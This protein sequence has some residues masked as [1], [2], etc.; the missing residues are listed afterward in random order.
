MF[1]IETG[2]QQVFGPD[3][4]QD[5]ERQVHIVRENPRIAQSRQKSYA[6][7]RWRELSFEVVDYVY[8]KLSPMRRLWCLKVQ[9]KLALRFIGPFK[10]ME[11]RG[12]MAYQLE[13][14]P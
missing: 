11:M 1:W 5:V 10:I 4:L 7:Q 2:E 3:M 14:P 12:K 8:L 6:D 13:L 9:G